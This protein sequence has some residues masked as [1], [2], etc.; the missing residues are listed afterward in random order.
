M[1]QLALP[2]GTQWC[3]PAISDTMTIWQ[4]IFVD[5]AY[6]TFA[7]AVPR[8]GVVID[9]GAHTGLAS[10]FF[11]RRIANPRIY[12]F[13]PAAALY[14]CLEANAA[15]H[16]PGVTICRK[17]LG[18]EAARRQFSY[19]PNV[20]SQS[21]L[22]ADPRTDR[23]STIA[24]L[25]NS[26]ATREDAEYLSEGAHTAIVEPVEVET[27]SAVLSQ[28]DLAVVDLLKIDVERA[29]LDVL[30]GIRDDHWNAIRAIIMEVHDEDDRLRRSE[31]MLSD[32]G[33][34]VSIEQVPWLANS[35]LFNLAAR[36]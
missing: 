16:L 34:S 2:D 9:V 24:Y 7:A 11:A 18:S 32:R 28:H 1:R 19:Y 13:E 36:R 33:Y 23:E 31:R 21:G 10:L 29:E 17:A 8:S 25:I 3:C 22:Y 6:S 14:E 27:L 12:A 5:Q 30:N 35:R 4:E 20:P 15:S 26:G